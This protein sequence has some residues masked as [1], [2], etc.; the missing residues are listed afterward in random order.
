[1]NKYL[2]LLGLVCVLSAGCNSDQRPIVIHNDDGEFKTKLMTAMQAEEDAADA[3][4]KAYKE[5]SDLKDQ[6]RENGYLIVYECA[7]ADRDDYDTVTIRDSTTTTSTVYR[8][9]GYYMS[10]M[11]ITETLFKAVGAI[12]KDSK[13]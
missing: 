2:A 6:V 11:H 1:M 12:T 7:D 3:Y 5:A 13:N 4:Q 8:Y 9:D 10:C